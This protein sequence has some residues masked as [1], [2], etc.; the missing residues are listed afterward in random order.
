MDINNDTYYGN[1]IGGVNEYS[2]LKFNGGNIGTAAKKREDRP[3]RTTE[4]IKE[5]RSEEKKRKQRRANEK[6]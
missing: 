4:V 5:R 3:L 2:Q 1:L 6:E